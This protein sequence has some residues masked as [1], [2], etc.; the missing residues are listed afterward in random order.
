MVWKWDDKDDPV[1]RGFGPLTLGLAA[2]ACIPAGPAVRIALV[3]VVAAGIAC[4]GLWVWGKERA[5]EAR[6]E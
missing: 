2:A 1:V 5:M 6:Q 4:G 3:V